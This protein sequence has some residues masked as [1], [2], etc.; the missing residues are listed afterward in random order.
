METHCKPEVAMG[1]QGSRP[2]ADAVTELPSHPGARRLDLELKEVYLGSQKAPKTLCGVGSKFAKAA[3]RLRTPHQF[4]GVL[5]ALSSPRTELD[6]S[7]ATSSKPLKRPSSQGKLPPTKLAAPALPAPKV[8]SLPKPGLRRAALERDTVRSPWKSLWKTNG[9]PY[10]TI[11]NKWNSMDNEVE[12][13]GN[14]G[15][16]PSEPHV[17]DFGLAF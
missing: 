4:R 1:Q 15:Q 16:G 13:H 11:D 6:V 10:K 12:N 9:E 5:E 14:V 8:R 3:K 7:P 2:D 17:I